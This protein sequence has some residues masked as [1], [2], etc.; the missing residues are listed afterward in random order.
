MSA[1]TRLFCD[2]LETVPRRDD[3]LILVTG[4]SGYVGGRLVPELLARG[5]R[6]R[7]MFRNCQSPCPRS[8]KG[9]EVAYADC[10]DPDQ[11][12]HALRRVDVAYYLIHSMAVRGEDFETPDLHSASTFRSLAAESGVQ[13]IVYLGAL[14]GEKGR[15]SPHLRSRLRVEEVLAE[16]PVPTTTLRAGIIVGSGSASFEM[17]RSIVARHRFVPIVRAFR[18]LCQPIAIRDVLKYLVGVL[19]VPETSGRTFDIGGP[20]VLTYRQMLA[21]C[22]AA[23]GRRIHVAYVPDLWPGFVAWWLSMVSAVPRGIASALLASLQCDVV[24]RD[25]SIRRWLGFRSIPFREAVQRALLREALDDVP[26]RWADASL[27][28]TAGSDLAGALVNRRLRRL[29]ATRPVEAPPERVF[30]R[31]ARIGGDHGWLHADWAWR[32]RGR[33]DSLLGG[34]GLKRGRRSRSE[35]RTGD[36]VDFWRVEDLSPGRRLLLRSEMRTPGSAWLEFRLRPGADGETIVRVEAYYL[37][38]G[39]WGLLYW[40]I[41]LPAHHY[42]FHGMLRRLAREMD[43]APTRSREAEP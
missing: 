42:L 10:R 32:L 36:T 17:I 35:L 30:D 4:A 40:Y 25:D 28:I 15:V 9:V 29:G 24:C 5:Y 3:P 41:L 1:G 14:H 27:G 31:L 37:P 22:A 43:P 23:M 12:R 18:C 39:A 8:W 34:V 21:D 26:T 11:L 7:A 38:Q 20:A 13:R 2:D 16:G 6:V 19:E 33:L